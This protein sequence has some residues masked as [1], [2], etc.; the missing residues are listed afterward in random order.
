MD[1]C[2]IYTKPEIL[3]VLAEDRVKVITF[4][5]RAMHIFQALDLSLF[6]VFKKKINY[7][8]PFQNDETTVGFIKR[9][10]HNLK[11]SLVEDN[12][13]SAFLHLGLPYQVGVTPCLLLFN[14]NVLR[15][16]QG[17]QTL[18]ERDYPMEALSYK[19][20]TETFGWINEQMAAN[21]TA[22]E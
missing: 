19:K 3:Q 10:F 9:V 21:R 12:V 13:R 7:Q 4:P 16:S 20:R 17:F 5:P 18:R 1:N 2:S 15:E 22:K 8:L 6:G 14:E 11:Q